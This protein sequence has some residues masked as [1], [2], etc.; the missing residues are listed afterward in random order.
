MEYS[1]KLEPYKGQATRYTC[2]SCGKRREFV[3]Y[4]Y[5]ANG[6]HI[7]ENVGRCNRV[8]R[9]GYHYTPSQYFKDTNNGAF[10]PPPPPT[11]K[12]FIVEKPNYTP[13]EILRAT[14]C[15][16]DQNNFI[17]FLANR[18]GKYAVQQILDK[19]AIGTAPNGGT[20]FWQI[21]KHGRIR[22]GKVMYYNRQTCKRNGII[23]WKHALD[24]EAT[25]N[26]KPCF[27]GEHLVRDS[28]QTI[29]IVES[30]KTAIIASL[31]F[32]NMIWIASS[33]LNGLSAEKSKALRGKEVVLYPDL[34]AGFLEWKQKAGAFG[35]AISDYL[36]SIATDDER[37]AGLDIADYLLEYDLANFDLSE[38]PPPT[39]PPPTQPPPTPPP[40]TRETYKNA[41]DIAP[42]VFLKTERGVIK[43]GWDINSN[44]ISYYLNSVVLGSNPFARNYKQRLTLLKE[45]LQ[46]HKKTDI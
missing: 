33:G 34:G 10:K 32:Q 25:Y 44:D 24:K 6:E 27:F 42:F 12:I 15:N 45:Y 3:R 31:Y 5:A 22:G 46:I 28:T 26:L 4:I 14:L 8:Q 40:I 1:T 17:Q 13:P 19:Y 41:I 39:P 35:F 43:S 20:I 30:E 23:T 7:H 9:C 37:S 29:C 11:P 21:D 38:P 18:F 2:P 16:Y 36:E